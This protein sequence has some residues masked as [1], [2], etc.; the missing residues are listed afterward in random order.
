[1][2]IRVF[3]LFENKQEDHMFSKILSSMKG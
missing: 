2:K 3:K 1:M